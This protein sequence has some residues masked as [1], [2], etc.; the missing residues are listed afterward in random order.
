MAAAERLT[1][2]LEEDKQDMPGCI[3]GEILLE[4]QRGTE[5]ALR[6]VQDL[7]VSLHRLQALE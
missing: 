7:H 4:Y 3:N 2:L 1:R 6:V 5:Q